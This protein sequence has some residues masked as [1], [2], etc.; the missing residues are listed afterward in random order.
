MCKRIHE[1]MTA[2]SPATIVG[3]S[4]I[5]FDEELLRRAFYASLLPIYLTN[6][7]GNSRLDVLMLIA[8]AY[9]FAP[10]A[11]SWPINEKGKVSFKLDRLAPS[12]GFNHQNA[13]D[14][15]ADVQ[16]TIH[17]ACRIRDLVPAVRTRLPIITSLRPSAT[18]KSA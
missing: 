1:V 9:A 18:I 5:S 16:A 12:N 7:G 8:A 2:W 15:L 4:S 10:A 3:Y 17:L 14:A 13:H 11:L 6:T